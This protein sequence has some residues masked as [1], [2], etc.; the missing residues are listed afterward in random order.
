MS[1]KASMAYAAAFSAAAIF[2]AVSPALAHTII[3][4]RVFPATMTV[5]DP[6][7]NDE[8]ALPQF[9]YLTNPDG[10]YTFTFQ[11]FYSKT[12]TADLAVSITS[13]FLHQVNP[14]VDGWSNIENEVKY[15][16]YSNP[17][18]EFIFSS[19]VSFEWGRTGNA[20]ASA[21]PF[22]TI[23]P[24][25]FVGK[26]FGDLSIDWLRPFAVTGELDYSLSTHPI[27]AFPT[28]DA[29][30]NNILGLNQTP[31]VLAWGGSIQYS[32]LYMNSFVHEVPDLFKRLIPT[33]E[34]QFFT[35]VSNIGPS[36]IGGNTH[37]TTGT[38]NFGTYYIDRYFEL[39]LE[40]VVPVNSASGKHVGA[41]AILD[42][43]LDDV[44]PDSIGKPLFGPA[45]SNNPD[46]YAGGAGRQMQVNR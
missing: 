9:T 14:H 33:V 11:G 17:E 18:H 32:L 43:F 31:T 8:L 26:G 5:D 34:A 4:N 46:I 16:L 25:I 37:T 3:G 19:A 10:S 28:Q 13:N 23:T 22:T 27:S 35:P 12:I 30:G 38:V 36:V 24:K 21:D 2:T 40:A 29:F 15:V 44:F 42:I 39:G 41:V 20:S 6:G 1:H 7:V 45:Q